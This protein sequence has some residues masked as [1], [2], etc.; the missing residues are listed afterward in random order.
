MGGGSSVSESL[1]IYSFWILPSRKETVYRPLDRISTCSSLFFAACR[2]LPSV[3]NW[4]YLIGL[5]NGT[6]DSIS[7]ARV[8]HKVKRQCTTFAN[9]R[10]VKGYSQAKADATT[11]TSADCPSCW[12]PIGP[13]LKSEQMRTR[14]PNLP[15][16]FHRFRPILLGILMGLW[17]S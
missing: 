9:V 12:L 1:M 3:S 15:T 7:M 11:A 17:G 5:E 10:A 13:I 6:V 2:T 8:S 4:M 16:G 14:P